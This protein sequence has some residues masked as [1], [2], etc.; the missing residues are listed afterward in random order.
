MDFIAIDFETANYAADS[1]CAIGLVKC[2]GGEIVATKECLIRPPT[3]FFSPFCVR[4]HGLTY[5]DVRDKP[6]FD[7]LWHRELR[8]FAGDLP[9]LAHNASFDRAVLRETLARYALA[10]TPVHWGCSLQMSRKILGRDLAY[11]Q[12][13][14]KLNSVAAHFGITFRHHNALE[15]SLAAARIAA[16]FE[17]MVGEEVFRGFFR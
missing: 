5:R 15:D 10:P 9:L 17:K 6:T 1:A 12:P 7:V 14:F 3:L 13:N 2:A 16:E 8:D 4:I 11:R